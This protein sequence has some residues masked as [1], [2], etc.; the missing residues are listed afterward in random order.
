MKQHKS[1]AYEFAQIRKCSNIETAGQASHLGH[2]LG[3]D[4]WDS[5]A[6]R[7]LYNNDI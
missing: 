1:Q 4:W 3:G 7:Q 6:L 5:E 2:A